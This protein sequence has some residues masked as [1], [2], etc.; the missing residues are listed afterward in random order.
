LLTSLLRRLSVGL[1]YVPS[2][3]SPAVQVTARRPPA[4]RLPDLEIANF[5]TSGWPPMLRSLV[6]T[7]VRIAPTLDLWPILPMV[8]VSAAAKSYHFGGGF[9]HGSRPSALG[10]DRQ[11][12]LAAWRNIHLIDASVF[13]TVPATTFTLTIMANAHRIAS[14]VLLGSGP[15]A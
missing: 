5:G 13:P 6:R 8:S 9:P 1:G 4:D 7:M 15:P 10:T 12:R 14:E 3:G 11:G 2:W